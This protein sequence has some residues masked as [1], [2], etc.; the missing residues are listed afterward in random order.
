VEADM[1]DLLNDTEVSVQSGQKDYVPRTQAAPFFSPIGGHVAAAL[2]GAAA[3][4]TNFWPLAFAQLPQVI[5]PVR[6]DEDIQAN[7]YINDAPANAMVGV[8]ALVGIEA[9]RMDQG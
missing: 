5:I 9:H 8:L 2:D 1:N 4:V 6:P 7:V 3:A